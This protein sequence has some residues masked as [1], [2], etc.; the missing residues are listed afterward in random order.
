MKYDENKI[1][2]EDEADAVP[3]PST[4][5]DKVSR[6][7]DK[8]LLI[9]Y[10]HLDSKDVY[11]ILDS[12]YGN[13]VNYWYDKELKGGDEWNDIVRDK[14]LSVDCVGVIIFISQ[15]SILRSTIAEEMQIINQRYDDDKHFLILPILIDFG[16]YNDV[17]GFFTTTLLSRDNKPPYDLFNTFAKLSAQGNRLFLTFNSK[18][19]NKGLTDEIV[20]A[21]ENLGVVDGSFINTRG[22]NINKLANLVIDKGKYIY[23]IGKYPT[24]IDGALS[25]IEWLLVGIE[26]DLL[27][28]VSLYCLDFECYKKDKFETVEKVKHAIG[29]IPYVESLDIMS[30]ET[31][32]KYSD[33]IGFA[34][35]TDYADTQRAQLLKLFWVENNSKIP[36]FYNCMNKPVAADFLKLNSS[37]NAGVRLVLKISNNKINEV[38]Y[39]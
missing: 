36:M 5:L 39:E 7:N 28:F 10:A 30:E 15:T 9:S 1:R 34:V 8:F 2:N 24:Q 25:P 38:N 27:I 22:S 17:Y 6:K 23:K 37:F 16:H 11:P 4:Y 12:L 35:S 18:I 14:L 13:G 21:C 32:K 31:I 33:K 20:R 26:D 29:E 19:V 3:K